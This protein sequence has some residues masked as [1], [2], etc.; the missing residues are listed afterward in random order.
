MEWPSWYYRLT[1]IA[2]SWWTRWNPSMQRGRG[3]RMMMK[4]KV[5]P[6]VLRLSSHWPPSPSLRLVLLTLLSR[7]NVR[8]SPLIS[9]AASWKQSHPHPA[10]KKDPIPITHVSSGQS[11]SQ[12]VPWRSTLPLPSPAKL[13]L[14]PSYPFSLRSLWATLKREYSPVPALCTHQKAVPSGGKDDR[15]SP[16]PFSFW[17][18]DQLS[19]RCQEDITK[20]NAWLW[21]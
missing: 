13:Y 15:S 3:R 5:I 12:I 9:S 6:S 18:N 20:K 4:S 17:S 7:L 2:S 19:R 8:L 14:P 11:L 21:Y 1:S 10:L 16:T